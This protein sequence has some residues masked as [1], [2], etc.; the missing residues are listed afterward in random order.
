M[1]KWSYLKNKL[2]PLPDP[3]PKHADLVE[4]AKGRLSGRSL[5]D[6]L[7]RYVQLR[8]LKQENEAARAVLQ[9]EI[10]AVE[11]Y[12]KEIFEREDVHKMTL[13]TGETIS[14]VPEP[15]AVTIDPDLMLKW[16]KEVGL[17]KSLQLPWQT[18][19]SQ[20]KQLLEHGKDVMPGVKPYIRTT[21]RFRRND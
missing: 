18:L 5:N 21:V 4:A 14:T 9:I 2:P 1:G 10:D 3:D 15:H 13:E 11:D 8:N 6:Y 16:V 20:L 12:I 19:N 17:E 7:T